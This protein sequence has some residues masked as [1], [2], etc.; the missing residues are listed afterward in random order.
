MNGYRACFI[1]FAQ[2]RHDELLVLIIGLVAKLAAQL[3][4]ELTAALAKN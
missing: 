3:V 2:R 4:A 1:P